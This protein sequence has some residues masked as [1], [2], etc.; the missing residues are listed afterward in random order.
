[1]G[2][3]CGL[4]ISPSFMG[5]N[6]ENTDYALEKIEQ[7]FLSSWFFKIIILDTEQPDCIKYIFVL[8]HNGTGRRR[9]GGGAS[10]PVQIR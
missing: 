2:K 7:F 10:A 4:N 5:L 1:M 3:E 6:V 8:L 9:G